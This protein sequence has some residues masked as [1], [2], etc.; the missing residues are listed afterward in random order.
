MTFNIYLFII[1]IICISIYIILRKNRVIKK[2]KAVNKYDLIIIFNKD[3]YID[4]REKK[5]FS[6]LAN[7]NYYS[8]NGF[9]GFCT[10][11]KQDL[12]KFICHTLNLSKDDFEVING[13][14]GLYVPWHVYYSICKGILNFDGVSLK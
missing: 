12:E 5:E 8:S 4:I 13:F 7:W 11:P 3:K 1:A 9:R 10:I 6:N 2:K 14:T